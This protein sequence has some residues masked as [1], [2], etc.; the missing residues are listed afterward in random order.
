MTTKAIPK[1][2][3]YSLGKRFIRALKR[4]RWLYLI[5][6]L[7]FVY[8]SC[9]IPKRKPAYALFRPIPRT[10]VTSALP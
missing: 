7:P 10:A 1:A 9:T 6:L 2:S 8:Y 5:M 4:D 3:R